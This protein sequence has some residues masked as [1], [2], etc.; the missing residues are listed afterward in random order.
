MDKSLVDMLDDMMGGKFGNLDRHLIE[1]VWRIIPRDNM[2]GP[3][4]YQRFVGENPFICQLALYHVA[5]Q[6]DIDYPNVISS[7]YGSSRTETTTNGEFRSKRIELYWIEKDFVD[8]N[9]EKYV[10]EVNF[11]LKRSR[12]G[13]WKISPKSW[14]KYTKDG[15]L[16]E[17]RKITWGDV[18]YW[19]V[20]RVNF[21]L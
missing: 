21:R 4:A 16:V 7:Q 1:H 2:R 9:V 10:T 3:S 6:K 20:R 19:L 18:F 5:M 17:E 14:Y 12:D 13:I 8:R 11:L 15:D